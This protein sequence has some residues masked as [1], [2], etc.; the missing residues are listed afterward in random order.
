MS[1]LPFCVFVCVLLPQ[2]RVYPA[3]I[4]TLTVRG[5]TFLTPMGGWGWVGGR[6]RHPLRSLLTY[7]ARRQ[8]EKGSLTTVSRPHKHKENGNVCIKPPPNPS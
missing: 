3:T 7:Q 6:P 2:E 1:D 8:K 4:L 5:P